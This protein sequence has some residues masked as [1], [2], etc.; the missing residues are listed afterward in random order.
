M[1]YNC[2]YIKDYNLEET[3]DLK[4]INYLFLNC[5]TSNT[6]CL[7]TSRI[8]ADNSLIVHYWQHNNRTKRRIS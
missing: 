8:S 1:R 2:Y 4:P 6:A 3:V 5:C 7:G